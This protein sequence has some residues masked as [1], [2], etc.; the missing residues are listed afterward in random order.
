MG[1]RKTIQEKQIEQAMK[2]TLDELGRKITVISSR[3]SK[4]S[5][6]Q[7]DHLRDSANW[8]V[9]PFNVLNVSQNYY[10]KYN[11]PKGQATPNDRSNIT[12][13]PL[14]NAIRDCVP[15]GV[16]VIVKDLIDILKAQII[17]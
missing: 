8:R 5:K 17:K 7:K 10:G 2:K 15:E 13:T 14:L 1:R 6:L 11:T 4:V 3:N 9:K 16:N 12:N